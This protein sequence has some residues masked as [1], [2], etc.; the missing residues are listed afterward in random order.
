LAPLDSILPEHPDHRILDV[1]RRDI[2]VHIDLFQ[3]NV[4]IAVEVGEQALP[5]LSR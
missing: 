3:G 1:R 2:A 4:P 5:A